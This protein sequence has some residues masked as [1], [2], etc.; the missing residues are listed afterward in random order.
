MAWV[1]SCH[2][3]EV[4]GFRSGFPTSVAG[5]TAAAEEG[6]DLGKICL[7]TGGASKSCPNLSFPVLLGLGGRGWPAIL[8]A[9]PEAED[10]D[11]LQ[12]LKQLLLG[13]C[14][15][16]G[17]NLLSDLRGFSFRHALLLLLAPPPGFPASAASKR[18]RGRPDKLRC[19]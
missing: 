3:R 8:V 9:P 13:G 6:G 16:P 4:N 7:W 5:R 15:Q 14:F 17:E 18:A 12:D 10:P 1:R 2:G 19:V 11:K